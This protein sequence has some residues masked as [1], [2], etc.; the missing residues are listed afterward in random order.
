[1]AELAADHGNVDALGTEL[2]GVGVAQTVSVDALEDARAASQ[3]R[4]E[5]SHPAR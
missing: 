1:M 2:G 5:S 4:H 3:A